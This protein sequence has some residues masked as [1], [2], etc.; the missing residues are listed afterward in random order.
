MATTPVS[1]LRKLKPYALLIEGTIVLFVLALLVI[2]YLGT[3]VG[4]IALPI[5]AWAAVLLL[6]P[7]QPDAKLFVL[8]LIGTAMLITIVVEVVVVS[9]D[10]GRQ[11]TIFKFY[12]QAW[13][14]LAVSA[15]AAFAWVLPAFFRWLPGWR[16]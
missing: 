7:N 8:F 6:R 9:G 4:W 3:S 11:N 13:I 12:M 2:Q 5:A 16:W 1:A 10:I 14:L 15:A